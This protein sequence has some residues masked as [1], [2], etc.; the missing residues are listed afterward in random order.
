MCKLQYDTTT[1]TSS[2]TSR[3]SLGDSSAFLLLFFCLVAHGLLRFITI[4]AREHLLNVKRFLGNFK[5]FA[6]AKLHLLHSFQESS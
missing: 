5:C 2:T 4:I 1:L 3:S 6:K